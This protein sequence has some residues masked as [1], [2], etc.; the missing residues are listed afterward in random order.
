MKLPYISFWDWKIVVIYIT[1]VVVEQDSSVHPISRVCTYIMCSAYNTEAVS[2]LLGVTMFYMKI[3]CSCTD[4]LS[5][6]RATR[7]PRIV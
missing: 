2:C 7:K 6:R 1:N 5:A 3:N 4:T